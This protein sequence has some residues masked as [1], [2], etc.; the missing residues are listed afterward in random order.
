MYANYITRWK[1]DKGVTLKKLHS[2]PDS[3][4]AHVHMSHVPTPYYYSQTKNMRD[5]MSF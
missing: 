1:C 3:L 4:L 2:H 5:T